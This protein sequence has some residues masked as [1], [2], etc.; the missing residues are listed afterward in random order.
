MNKATIGIIIALLLGLGGLAV[1]T[2]LN[3]SNSTNINSYDSTKIIAAD[4]SNGNIADYVRGKEDSE[5]VVVEYA[6]PQCP[7]C[8]SMMPKMSK[9]YEEYGDRVAFVFRTYPM[10]YHQNAR[11]A[12]AA[13]MSAGYQGFFWEMLE[14]L[15]DNQSD[16]ENIFDTEKRTNTFA[17]FF[18]NI[19]GEKADIEKFKSDLSD[20]NIQ[21]KID[22]DKD[23]GKKIDKVSE[24]P[25]IYVN[26]KKVSISKAEGD[27]KDYIEKFINEALKEKGLE[28]GPTKVSESEEK[29]EE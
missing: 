14:T 19:A 25:S 1:Y 7:G 24:T 13:A 2:S 22:F 17:V 18:E 29:T 5:V 26:G 28:T 21:K 10:S 6:D 8:A 27:I 12:A 3:P 23:L 9:L 11:S 20:T 4:D 15:Y 16:W